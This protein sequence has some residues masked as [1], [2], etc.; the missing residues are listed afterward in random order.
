MSPARDG[1]K[2]VARRLVLGVL[3][4]GVAAF[5]LQG[6]EY[7]TWDLIRARVKQRHISRAIDSLRHDVDSLTR[8]K[9]RILTDPAMQERIAREEFGMI[10]GNKE[11]LFRFVEP[12]S[13]AR[14]S[15]QP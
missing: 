6:G 2:A 13:A 7:G 12:E 10:K 8:L 4:V 5:A 15:P 11:I 3:A 14:R 9:K 1:R